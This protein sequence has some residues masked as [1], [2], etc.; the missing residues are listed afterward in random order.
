MSRPRFEIA[1]EDMGGWLW[2]YLGRGEPTGE[3]AKFLS[4]SLT[5][6]MRE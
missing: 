6:W 5:E 2:V 4:H 1:R 3:V